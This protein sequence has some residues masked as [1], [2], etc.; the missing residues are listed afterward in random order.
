MIRRPPRSTLFPYTTLFRSMADSHGTVVSLGERECSIQRRHQK[1]LEETPSPA[2][3]ARLRE[4]I[5]QA[6]VAAAKAVSYVG[7]GTVEFILAPTGEFFFLEMNTR[8]Q[9][10]HPITECVVGVDIVR[11]QLLVAEGGA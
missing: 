3:D 8:L 4:E 2:V 5:C 10:E 11:L 7:A 1:V 6:A 9:V